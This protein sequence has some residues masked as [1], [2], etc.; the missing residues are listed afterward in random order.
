M[1]DFDGNRKL[2]FRTS[3]NKSALSYSGYWNNICDLS[4][5]IYRP[6]YLTLSALILETNNELL[7]EGQN[8]IAF[9]LKFD[10]LVGKLGGER[11]R[12]TF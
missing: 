6:K 10:K 7:L 3:I 5:S 9:E 2:L 8:E 4:R 12:S 11:T 1:L